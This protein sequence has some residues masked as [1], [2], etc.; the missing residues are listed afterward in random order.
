MLIT[1]FPAELAMIYSGPFEHYLAAF[2]PMDEIESKEVVTRRD[3]KKAPAGKVSLMATPATKGVIDSSNEGGEFPSSEGDANVPVVVEQVLEEHKRDEALIISPT[4][5]SI[6]S[7]PSVLKPTSVPTTVKEVVSRKQLV[8]PKA[9]KTQSEKLI[10]QKDLEGQFFVQIAAVRRRSQ[11]EALVRSFKGKG[12][13]LR[14]EKTISKG[15]TLYRV[16]SLPLSKR[17]ATEFAD[18][19]VR[20]NLVAERPFMR[21]A[22]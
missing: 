17:K 13:V 9:K 15:L 20:D 19:L 3:A 18:K 10:A 2:V 8:I 1:F 22:E 11:A 7:Q 21:K 4:I 12:L 5:S 16:V 6:V 14:M